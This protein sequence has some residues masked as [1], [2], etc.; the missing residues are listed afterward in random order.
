[1][2]L[3][4]AQDH[5]Y[6]AAQGLVY[7]Y[8]KEGNTKKHIGEELDFVWTHLF[9]DGKLAFQAAYS[10]LFAG[11]YIQENLGTST[12]QDWAYAQLWVNF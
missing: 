8:S 10:H 9:M 7:V 12:D 2:N 4:N 5:W 3:A 11:G 1:L 6:R